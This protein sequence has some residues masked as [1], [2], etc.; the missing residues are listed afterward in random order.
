[1]SSD[2]I[3]GI[4]ISIFLAVG[5]YYV[6]FSSS[7]SNDTQP[8]PQP[9]PQPQSQ[10]INCEYSDWTDSGTPYMIGSSTFQNQVRSKLPES[11]QDCVEQNTSQQKLLF[12]D[13]GSSIV[14]ETGK[15]VGHIRTKYQMP[16]RI[17]YNFDTI[18]SKLNIRI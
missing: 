8:Q 13:L 12:T 18:T 4:I 10:P 14:N 2:V 15:T 6:F 9:Q 7:K 11:S 3:I 1:M 16:Q 5:I 17:H